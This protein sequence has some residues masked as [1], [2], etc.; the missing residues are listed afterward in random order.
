M[1]S[2]SM[3][4]LK[5]QI[6]EAYAFFN[7]NTPRNEIDAHLH[8]GLEGEVELSIRDTKDL[9]SDPSTDP[10][11][12]DT[13]REQTIYPFYPESFRGGVLKPVLM[14]NLKYVIKAQ[15]SGDNLDAARSLAG[16]MND[17]YLR[18]GENKPFWMT[19]VGK[20][21]GEYCEYNSDN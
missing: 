14:K 16:V 10:K 1:I 19:V 9:E 2:V 20:D 12:L 5:R 3:V 17:V 21:N 18:F 13:M 15:T 11:L 6:G 4:A 8:E 7:C